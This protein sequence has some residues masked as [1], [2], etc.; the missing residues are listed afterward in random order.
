MLSYIIQRVRYSIVLLIVVSITGY[1]MIELPPGDYLTILLTQQLQQGDPGAREYVEKLR[2]RYGLDQPVYT[3]YWIWITHFVQGDF[4][5]SFYYNRPVG[6]LIGQRLVLTVVL[7]LATMVLTWAIA[8][9]IG[10]YSA[11]HQYSFGD[12]IFTT[13]SFIGLGIPG[14]LLALIAMFIMVF[15]YNQEVGGL[16]SQGYEDA[17]WT[18][19][20]II[21]LLKH[22]WLPA[23]ISAV[24]GTAGL[25]RIMRSNLLEILGQPFVLA[26][27][28]KGLKERVVI[29]KHAARMAINPLISILGMSLPEIISG[30]ALVSIVL[31]LPTVGP[32]F[33]VALQM[34]DMYLAGTFM[35]FLTIMLI[36]GN[37]LA[38]IALVWADPRIRYN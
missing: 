33:L 15:Y 36:V 7:T 23:L 13:I 4:G 35:L 9:P 28:A 34:Q 20:K 31:N 38:D 37:L 1:M 18:L 8:I 30:N 14:F 16:F 22:L 10:I 27:R 21:D 17:P 12:Q 32:M 25:I 26:A 5:E 24:S 2:G 6:D 3:R 19:A 29:T 11:T